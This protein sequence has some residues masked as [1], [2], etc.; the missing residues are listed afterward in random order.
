MNYETAPRDLNLQLP[1][2]GRLYKLVLG[3]LNNQQV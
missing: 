1:S 3:H 2:F